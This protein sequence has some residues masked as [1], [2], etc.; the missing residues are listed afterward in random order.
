[1]E[2]SAWSSR[3]LRCIA[4]IR[5][6]TR[7]HVNVAFPVRSQWREKELVSLWRLLDSPFAVD[8]LIREV[9]LD[10]SFSRIARWSGRNSKMQYSCTTVGQLQLD[11]Y[12]AVVP[13]IYSKH[14]QNRSIWD[15]WCH[16]LHHG[17]AVAERIRKNAPQDKL[18]TEIADFA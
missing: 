10:R 6:N 18:F 5:E 3:A 8:L 4:F 2:L 15:V 11:E 17:A 16:T 13:K 7:Q 1:M 14:D 9:R 12:V